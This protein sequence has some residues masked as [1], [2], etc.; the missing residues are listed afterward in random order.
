MAKQYWLFKSEP[1]VYS[2][3]DLK[4]DRKTMWEGVRNYSAR[5]FLRQ[6]QK[7]DGVLF[8]HSQTK[9]VAGLAEVVKEAYPDPTQFEKKSKYFD[10]KSNKEDPRWSVVD[11]KFVEAFDDPP[12]LDELK[13][14]ATLKE[15]V[16]LR[17]GRLSVQP[18]TAREWNA[19]V[20]KAR[21]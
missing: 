18:V 20:K 4:K 12:T 16:L 9:E 5:N 1:A 2:I 14:M 21:R 19:I 8:Y 13:Q 7:G 15:M 6:A 3:A 17:R 10:A 11:V